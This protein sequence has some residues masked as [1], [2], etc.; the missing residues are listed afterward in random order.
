[1]VP[2]LVQSSVGKLEVVRFVGQFIAT[3]MPVLDHFNIHAGIAAGQNVPVS[4]LGWMLLYCVIYSVFALL[5]ALV[6]FED[7]DLA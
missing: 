1:L 2:L 5:G 4:Y 7:R 6:L 3:V